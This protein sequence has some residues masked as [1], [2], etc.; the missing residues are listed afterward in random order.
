MVEAVEAIP[1][2]L[3]VWTKE[4]DERALSASTWAENILPTAWTTTFFHLGL[5]QKYL[6]GQMSL[7]GQ[8]PFAESC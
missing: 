4:G 7:S 1:T 2:T 6:A 3:R 5:S 8:P